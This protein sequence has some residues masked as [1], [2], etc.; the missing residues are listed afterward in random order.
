MKT[1]SE[2]VEALAA[3]F[4]PEQVSFRVGSTNKKKFQEKQTDK[5]K[6]QVL[7][8]LDARDV[9][10]RLNDVCGPE[11]WQNRYVPMPNGT[12]CCEIG[13]RLGGEWVWKANGADMLPDRDT[14]DAR[15]MAAK[16]AYSDGFKRAAVLWGVGTYLY[17]MDAPWVELD[18]W[19][20]IPDA[21]LPKLRAMLERKGGNAPAAV[22]KSAYAARKDGHYPE[23]EKRIRACETL[24][25]LVDV[26]K[27]LQP[28][29]KEM[30]AGWQKSI[31]E[32]KDR[33]KS[34]LMGQHKEAAE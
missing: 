9:M 18:E 7:C 14:A 5:R 17:D 31:A 12:A 8:F 24:T 19:W 10:R 23:C 26:W 33:K 2:I 32:E 4:P 1:V 11:N 25:D 30:P 16:G 15:E 27:Q 20:G 34:E 3:P 6:G 21:A 28:Y 22:P 29:I 13:I